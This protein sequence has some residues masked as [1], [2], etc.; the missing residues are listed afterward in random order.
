M[1]KALLFAAMVVALAGCSTTQFEQ[2][3]EKTSVALTS[4]KEKANKWLGVAQE[5]IE[6]ARDKAS[7]NLAKSTLK[8]FELYGNKLTPSQEAVAEV[9]VD[10][11]T[12]DCTD[13]KARHTL[14]FMLRPFTQVT[15]ETKDLK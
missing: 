3:K 7:C 2:A 8:D 13:A 12:K 11:L 5:R 1:K 6:Q 15:S 4:A 10:V 14:E 9:A